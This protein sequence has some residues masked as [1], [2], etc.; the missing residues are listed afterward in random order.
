[1]TMRLA[2]VIALGALVGAR[3]LDSRHGKIDCG[4]DKALV[5]KLCKIPP[6]V[7]F[8]SSLFPEKTATHTATITISTT[9]TLTSPTTITRTST[10]GVRG[11]TITKTATRS[12]T[13]A[14]TR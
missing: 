3:S 2:V 10:G 7:S 12:S 8:C 11:G 5:D 13:T 1:V 9:R 14:T 4:K 6:V